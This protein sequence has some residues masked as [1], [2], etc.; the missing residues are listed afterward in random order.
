M[1]SF[2]YRTLA[3]TNEDSRKVALSVQ[4]DFVDFFRVTVEMADRRVGT[5]TNPLTFK[6]DDGRLI[7][8][9]PGTYAFGQHR[10]AICSRESRLCHDGA[11]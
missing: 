8:W 3:T 2:Q 10:I 7:N 9:C 4:E 6:A 5:V 1:R 11:T